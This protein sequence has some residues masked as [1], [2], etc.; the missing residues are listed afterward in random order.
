M[1]EIGSVISLWSLYVHLG[2]MSTRLKVPY[3]R[4][5]CYCE[6]GLTGRLVHIL[7]FERWF[8]VRWKRLFLFLFVD[9]R[10]WTGSVEVWLTSIEYPT[11]VARLTNWV[12]G[13]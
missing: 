8:C 10:L 4:R 7:W 1:V 9:D 6:A 2:C 3:G 12:C 13:W 5:E 11:R